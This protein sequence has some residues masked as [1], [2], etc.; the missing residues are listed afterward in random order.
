MSARNDKADSPCIAVCDYLPDSKVCRGCF[1]R[2]EEIWDWRS[3]DESAR[4]AVLKKTK[5]RK[6]EYLAGR[7]FSV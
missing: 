1:R 5:L 2:I 3:L 7:E 6:T 4:R